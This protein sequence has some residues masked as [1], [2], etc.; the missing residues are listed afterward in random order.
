VRSDEILRLQSES[1]VM[2][3]AA[4]NPPGLR[5]AAATRASACATPA[6]PEPPPVAN[7]RDFRRFRLD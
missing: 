6:L 3:G 7:L 4:N 2:L 5:A 1:A